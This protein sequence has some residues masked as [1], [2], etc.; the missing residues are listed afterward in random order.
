[1]SRPRLSKEL[2]RGRGGHHGPPEP[3]KGLRLHAVCQGDGA[4][5][6]TRIESRRMVGDVITLGSS[7]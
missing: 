4:A 5:A 2:L 6:E 1:M 7:P 3:G